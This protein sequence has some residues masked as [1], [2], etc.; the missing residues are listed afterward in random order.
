MK[1]QKLMALVLALAM[2]LSLGAFPALADEPA[3]EN[4]IFICDGAEGDGSSAERIFVAMPRVESG[5]SDCQSERR[6]ES[7]RGLNSPPSFAMPSK[8]ASALVAVSASF[9]VL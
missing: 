5:K 9:R 2:V 8:I 3:A 4:V 7:E 6:P 1:I